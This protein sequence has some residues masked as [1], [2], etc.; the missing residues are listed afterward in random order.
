MNPNILAD[1]QPQYSFWVCDGKVLKNMQE[2]QSALRQM[3]SETYSC[4]ANN[5]K[6]DFANWV[7]DILSDA[8]L[9]QKLRSARSK[10][11]A[12]KAVGNAMR[13]AKKK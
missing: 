12:E 3:S 4:H 10:Q 5:E 11:E 6:N 8:N 7:N 2:L 1:V 13:T 9:A